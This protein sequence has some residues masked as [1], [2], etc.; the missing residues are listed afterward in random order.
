MVLKKEMI[1]RTLFRLN[2]IELLD[3]NY[4]FFFDKT[5]NLGNA[6]TILKKPCAKLC[7][8]LLQKLNNK[9]A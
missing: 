7:N 8:T 4:C 5:N 9:F 1:T 3:I 6:S 2:S